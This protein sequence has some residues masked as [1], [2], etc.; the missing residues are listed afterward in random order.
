[1]VWGPG[2]APKFVGSEANINQVEHMSISIFIQFVDGEPVII[3]DLEE[4][5]ELLSGHSTDEGMAH[6]DKSLN[7]AVAERFVPHFANDMRGT[8]EQLRCHLKEECT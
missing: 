1:M 4:D 6:A 8:V 3:L 5:K 2:F 7:I